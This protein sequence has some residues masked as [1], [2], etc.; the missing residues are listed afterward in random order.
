MASRFRSISRPAL[1]F[2]NHSARSSGRPL[3]PNALSRPSTAFQRVPRELGSLM[4][5][6]PLHS[7]VSSARL[8]S[9]LGFDSAR[10]LYQE[11]SLHPSIEHCFASKRSLH[12]PR[13]PSI[14]FLYLTS[15]LVLSGSN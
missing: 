7:A 9:R 3:F 10:S 6:L 1:S 15:V 2:I 5:L 12:Q 13:V 14:L 11:Q 8:T 4:S